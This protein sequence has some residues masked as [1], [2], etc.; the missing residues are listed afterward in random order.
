MSDIFVGGKGGFGDDV[1]QVASF[2]YY[3]NTCECASPGGGINIVDGIKTTVNIYINWSSCLRGVP[4]TTKNWI[5]TTKDTT[6]NLSTMIKRN[7]KH[8]CH[9]P[10]DPGG[11]KE[12]DEITSGGM[13]ELVSCRDAKMDGPFAPARNASINVGS[14]AVSAGGNVS[15]KYVKKGGDEGT[16]C[17]NT[18]SV[19][20]PIIGSERIPGQKD[21]ATVALSNTKTVKE[22]PLVTVNVCKTKPTSGAKRFYKVIGRG[23]NVT[24]PSSITVTCKVFVD[25]PA[26]VDAKGG[27]YGPEG[28]RRPNKRPG[29][30]GAAI[31]GGW[32]FGGAALA[33][34]K[35][36]GSNAI[37]L[38]VFDFI[39]AYN[40][41]IAEAGASGCGIISVDA[42]LSLSVG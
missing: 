15:V 32:D 24:A 20:I 31:D 3:Q 27:C 6:I 40:Q 39:Q 4:L 10:S 34:A 12:A 11:S 1:E 26:A 35:A 41:A 2:Q 33:A 30:I 8:N 29:T 28:E 17:G 25:C 36:Q 5:T 22:G 14:F 23:K 13:A 9:K 42:N 21:V 38:Y 19:S 37:K 7:P 16:S 18:D